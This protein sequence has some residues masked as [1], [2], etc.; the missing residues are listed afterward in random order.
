MA[1]S[2]PSK[3]QPVES[4]LQACGTDAPS[5]GHQH[6]R[7]LSS[8]SG[9]E[10][11]EETQF[12]IVDDETVYAEHEYS[13]KVLGSCKSWMTSMIVHLVVI[14]S[15]ALLTMQTTEKQRVHLEMGTDD[16]S[17]LT[18]LEELNFD[19]SDLEG[20]DQAD[21]APENRIPSELMAFQ[22]Q[23]DLQ[24]QPESPME[25][26]NPL[27]S[28]ANQMQ[29]LAREMTSHE[30]FAGDSGTSFFGIEAAGESVVYIVDRSGSMQGARWNRATSELLKSVNSLK[31]DQKFFVFLFSGK[32]H[33]MPQLAG[34]NKMVEATSREQG[35]VQE[36][37][38]KTV[39][40]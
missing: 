6:L 5:N 37:A 33:P 8:D 36:M 16:F 39:S 9:I 25:F 20:L 12:G 13:R 24:E 18:D 28:G 29:R 31:P 10:K 26:D 34:R 21:S 23:L 40:G 32:C 27:N 11:K 30:L 3:H 2:N 15:L 35:T 38:G 19:T 14:L 7:E 17:A 22:P 1:V 4:D